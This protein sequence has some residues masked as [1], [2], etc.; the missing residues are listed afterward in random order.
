LIPATMRSADMQS[1]S[2]AEQSR[3]PFELFGVRIGDL[4][5]TLPLAPDDSHS[6]HE[7]SLQRILDG[8]ELH[9]ATPLL[10]PPRPILGGRAA[11]VLGRAQR[12]VLGGAISVK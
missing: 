4:D 10:G 9:R 5:P 12:P 3:E 11:A 7:R 2:R 6:R 1:V 8:G